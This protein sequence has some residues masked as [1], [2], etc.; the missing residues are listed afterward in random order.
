ME[1]HQ[2]PGAGIPAL[3]SQKN[4]LPGIPHYIETGHLEPAGLSEGRKREGRGGGFSPDWDAL[5]VQMGASHSEFRV[6]GTGQV[7]IIEIGSRMGGDCI[8]S[9]LVRRCLRGRIL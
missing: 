7:R 9:H 1:N 6:D 4:L 8:G 2:L 3:P 5:G